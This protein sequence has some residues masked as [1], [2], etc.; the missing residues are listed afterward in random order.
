MIYCCYSLHCVTY[1]HEYLADGAFQLFNPLRRIAAGQQGGVD[2]QFFHGLG[3]PYLHYPFFRLFGGGLNGSEGAHHLVSFLAYMASYTVVFYA[4]T[5]RIRSTLILL[6]LAMPVSEYLGF[7][8]LITP[9]NS[10]IGVRSTMPLF[11]LAIL[12]ARLSRTRESLLFGIGLGATFL[13]GTEQGLACIAATVAVQTLRMFFG[14]DWKGEL[15][16]LGVRLGLAA[17]TAISFFLMV[18]GYTGLR[19]ALYYNLVQVPMDQFW[20][21]GAPPNYFLSS[22]EQLQRLEHRTFC[23]AAGIALSGLIVVFFWFITQPRSE[24]SAAVPY[25]WGLTYGLLTMTSVFGMSASHYVLPMLRI[26]LIF[27]FVLAWT[28][29]TP[30]ARCDLVS[31]AS[32]RTSLRRLVRSAPAAV[33]QLL[34]QNHLGVLHLEADRTRNGGYNEGDL[35]A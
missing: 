10:L 9:G 34:L 21:F 25:L 27:G 29:V 4:A 26:L 7:F 6:A 24:N 28:L 12:L 15:R 17:L 33:Q 3:I 23:H 8:S 35:Q 31:I 16:G 11:L 30:W 2:F 22:L 1:F 18:G 19:T 32:A 20:Y 5:R 13:L 14:V